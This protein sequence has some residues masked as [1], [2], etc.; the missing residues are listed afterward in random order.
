MNAI[1][2]LILFVP[3]IG[4]MGYF[5]VKL[6]QIIVRKDIPLPPRNDPRVEALERE[7]NELRAELSEV[8][9][10]V[11]FTQQLLNQRTEPAKLPE[12]TS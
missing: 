12:R 6:A 8:K 5:A 7:V 10:T 9:D 3:I 11:N 2:L 4:L 1:E